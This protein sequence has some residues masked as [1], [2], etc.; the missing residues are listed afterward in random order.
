[1]ENRP[2]SLKSNLVPL[3]SDVIHVVSPERS[4]NYMY[5]P[6]YS[7]QRYR[8]IQF[9]S[10][11]KIPTYKNSGYILPNHIG[12]GT[13]L[14]KHPFLANQYVN[15]TDASQRFRY[16]RFLQ[17]SEVLQLLGASRYEV[18]TV[19]EEV[20][21]RSWDVNGTLSIRAIK[22]SLKI[23][24]KNEKEKKVGFKLEDS[25]DGIKYISEDSWQQA[26]NLASKYGLMEDEFIHSII[27]QR[28]PHIKNAIKHRTYTLDVTEEENH[29]LDI[30]FALTALTACNLDVSFKKVV[31]EQHRM[32]MEIEY[33]F[34]ENVC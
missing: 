30:A 31:K 6:D 7:P 21:E 11:D 19:W 25:F 15:G 5:F 1:M 16:S 3:E 14:F 28:N 12:E 10:I 32:K 26:K 24:D 22:S 2:I 9:I 13:V 33:F 18:G 20:V 17:I 4:L 34:N 23:E 29:Y 8:G 27:N